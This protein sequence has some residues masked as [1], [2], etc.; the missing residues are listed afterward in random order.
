MPPR[1]R[2][3]E[4][5]MP[6]KKDRSV[7]VNDEYVLTEPEREFVFLFAVKGLP[8]TRAAKEAGYKSHQAHTLLLNKAGVIEAI[9]EAQA[10]NA[11]KLK[12]E[13]NDVLRGM[14]EA[15][16]MA[17]TQ[18]DPNGMVRGLREVG[19]I[20]GYYNHDKKLTLQIGDKTGE[21]LKTLSSED[22]LAI[23][24]GAKTASDLLPRTIEGELA[25][26]SPA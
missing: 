2:T 15:V 19:L 20:C 9:R 22:L 4:P 17:R 26:A 6:N 1:N 3:P 24:T 23:A 25:D 21:D 8:V 10:D 18:C 13:R 16:E 7:M 11:K 12:V 14:L 5:K